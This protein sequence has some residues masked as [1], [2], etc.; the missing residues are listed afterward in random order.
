MKRMWPNM[1]LYPGICLD[2]KTHFTPRTELRTPKLEAG[3]LP[4]Q[5]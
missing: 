2:E 4:N 5:Q 3:V 1:R